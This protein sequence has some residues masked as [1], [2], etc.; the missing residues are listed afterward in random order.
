MARNATYTQRQISRA[1]ELRD[2]HDNDREYRAALVFLFI[3]ELGHTA[4]EAAQFFGI[5]LRTVFGDLDRIRKPETIR[6]GEWGGGNNHLMT[7][8]EEAGFLKEYQEQATAGELMSMAEL[9]AEYNTRV[10]KETPKSTFYRVL[11]R[12]NWRK[13]L[14]GARH[15]KGDLALHGEFK[16][17]HSR[18]I[19]I[20]P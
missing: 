5:G 9:H 6:K 15:P 1:R 16:K 18:Y 14:P 19:W 13:V 20:W 10:G 2:N 12:H 8:D 7:F 3:A 17:K 11:K 4:E